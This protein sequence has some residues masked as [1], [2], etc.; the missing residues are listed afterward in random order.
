MNKGYWNLIAE[1]INIVRRARLLLA[2]EIFL[3]Y[4]FATFVW[5]EYA[6]TARSG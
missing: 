4:L 3:A 5:L 2:F 6:E 1:P